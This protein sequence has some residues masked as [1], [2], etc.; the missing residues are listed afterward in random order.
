MLKRLSGFFAIGLLLL[1]SLPLVAQNENTSSPYSRFGLGDI[2]PYSFGRF[3]AM[4]GASIGSRHNVQINT[5]NPASY[6]SIDS[7]SFV[8]EFGT[9]ARLSDFKSGE[10]NFKTND[11]NFRYFAF[12]FP[13]THWSAASMGVLPFSDKGYEVFYQEDNTE[14]G[15]IGYNYSG[16]GSISKAFL[17]F[18]V[19]LSKSIS[20]GANIYYL[21]GR[22]SQNNSILF[23]DD[24]S[25]YDY[26]ESE[27][28]R[29]RDLAYQ[30]GIQY[31]IPL[32]NDKFLT[33]GGTFENKPKFTAFHDLIRQNI[34]QTSEG[35]ITQNLDSIVDDRSTIQLPTSFGIGLSL[36]KPNK[37]EINADYY[38]SKWSEA[39]FFGSTLPE[40]TDQSR[41]ALGFEFIPDVTSLRNYLKKIKYRAGLHYEKSYLKI[42]NQQINE[43][44]MSFGFGLP[45]NRSKST[46][47]LAA[48]FGRRGTTSNG[49]IRENYTK[50]SVYL[51]LHDTWFFQRKF[52]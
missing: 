12:S 25:T 11:V 52:D 24:A 49:L 23:F 19:D 44:G 7:L 9:D 13:I 30:L 51:N 48:E 2:H 15:R 28:T 22:Q 43:F 26:T 50:L 29:V 20:V 32:K 1:S 37:Y 8:F 38:H 35:I 45:L 5:S 39:K 16:S 47:N 10:N 34:L 36:A 18:G 42:D 3:A 6:S 21:F 14:L 40:L 33:I 17:G 4:G 41:F 31:N 46:I 27:R